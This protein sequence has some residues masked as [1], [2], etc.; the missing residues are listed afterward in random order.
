MTVTVFPSPAVPPLPP[1]LMASEY[2]PSVPD[3]APGLPPFSPAAEA[4]LEP[5]AEPDRLPVALDE[6][7]PELEEPGA[8]EAALLDPP[9]PP[10]PP[11][12]WAKMPAAFGPRVLMKVEAPDVTVTVP[13]SPPPTDWAKMAVDWSPTVVM[14]E[15][16]V[17]F[18]V[19]PEPPV[20]AKPPMVTDAAIPFATLPLPF[21][22]LEPEVPD[23]AELTLLAVW[24]AP[25]PATEV[26]PPCSS[27]PCAA[28]VVLDA[29]PPFPPPPPMD[30]ARMP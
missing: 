5:L 24:P 26:T 15:L 30:W 18:T 12:D 17:T 28:L 16:L 21:C 23:T 25:D 3:C 22:G 27:W 13:P 19:E 10:P 2:P 14:A 6:A 11:T 9:L 4:V 8:L 7:P 1:R 29:A 20:P